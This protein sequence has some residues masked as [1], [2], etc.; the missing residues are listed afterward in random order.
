ME[1]KAINNDGKT[2]NITVL[3]KNSINSSAILN[4][5]EKLNDLKKIDLVN[6]VIGTVTD[7]K[8]LTKFENKVK[9]MGKRNSLIEAEYD[10]IKD[11]IFEEIDGNKNFNE[12]NEKINLALMKLEISGK[13]QKVYN[14]Y[15]FWYTHNNLKLEKM[16]SNFQSLKTYKKLYDEVNES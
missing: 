7:E 15:D 12:I 4:V 3:S 1:I 2:V 8:L 14:C 5:D 11:E 13:T 16:I 10:E 9:R 6:K